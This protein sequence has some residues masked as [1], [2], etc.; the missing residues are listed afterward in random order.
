MTA[1]AINLE[2]TA[3]ERAIDGI[4]QRLLQSSAAFAPIRARLLAQTLAVSEATVHRAV[5]ILKRERIIFA[6]RTRGWYGIRNRQRILRDIQQR[7]STTHDQVADL[8]EK[9]EQILPAVREI[10]TTILTFTPSPVAPSA[11][12][13]QTTASSPDGPANPKRQSRRSKKEN[14]ESSDEDAAE[15]TKENSVVLA[16][17]DIYA[18]FLPDLPQPS[19]DQNTRIA[20][21]RRKKILTLWNKKLKE[22]VFDQYLHQKRDFPEGSVHAEGDI[23]KAGLLYFCDYFER[24]SQSDFLTGKKTHWKASFD[25]LIEESNFIKVMEGNYSNNKNRKTSDANV[26]AANQLMMIRTDNE[27]NMAAMMIREH[28]EQDIELAV[29]SLV[30]SGVNPYPKNVLEQVSKRKRDEKAIAEFIHYFPE[31]AD[32][33]R[34]VLDPETGKLRAGTSIDHGKLA[35]L[36]YRIGIERQQKQ[37]QEEGRGGEFGGRSGGFF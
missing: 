28:G 16:F 17:M 31:H 6:G 25:W 36:R 12:S 26:E 34:G 5:A 3:I 35:D 15:K 20:K 30:M 37:A 27:K 21:K 1:T 24:V 10:Q 19:R 14:A 33:V 18:N 9:V 32:K 23:V 22:G 2:P 11:S 8:Q 29:R 4:V 13:D 7:I